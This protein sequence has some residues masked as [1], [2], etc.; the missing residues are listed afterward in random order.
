MP[1][2]RLHREAQSVVFNAFAL[3]QN[4]TGASHHETRDRMVIIRFRQ[5]QVELS[6]DVANGK[7]AVDSVAS[8][9]LLDD[10]ARGAL[11]VFV[12]D[13]AD[14][15]LEQILQRHQP[16][17]AAMFVNHNS[18]V[19]AG[20]AQGAQA[21]LQL[22]GVGQKDR[23]SND[24]FDFDRSAASHSAAQILVEQDADNVVESAAI[25][26]HA[27]VSELFEAVEHLLWGKTGIYRLDLGARNHYAFN[28]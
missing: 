25:D 1:R 5:A 14:D 6:I 11:V 9:R 23:R 17:D 13:V 20:A 22:H 24:L 4:A 7:V 26:R 10:L 15:L 16:F 8:V 2:G 12:A 27:R 28:R 3:A 18:E 21:L 19:I